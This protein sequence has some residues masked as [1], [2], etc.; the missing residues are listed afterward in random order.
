MKYLRDISSANNEIKVKLYDV[1]P[2]WK[3]IT[4]NP[5][6]WVQQYEVDKQSQDVT[7]YA[8]EAREINPKALNIYRYLKRG[9]ERSN[10]Y[11]NRLLTTIFDYVAIYS[12]EI[13]TIHK[14]MVNHYFRMWNNPAL[15]EYDFDA[16]EFHKKES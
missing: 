1:V 4:L 9:L 11:N 10:K 7:H 16:N 5:F 15:L 8:F 3:I 13:Q 2:L 12:T 14:Y 6:V